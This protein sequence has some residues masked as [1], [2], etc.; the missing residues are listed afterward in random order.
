MVGR[1]YEVQG[2]G[3]ENSTSG[4]RGPWQVFEGGLVHVVVQGGGWPTNVLVERVMRWSE[5]V[6]PNVIHTFQQGRD[7][8]G[9]WRS[10]IAY[11]GAFYPTFVHEGKVWVVTSG[12]RFVRPA[13]GM[14]RVLASSDTVSA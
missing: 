1:V 5:F 13:R 8:R 12:E 14:R 10:G 7:W 6:A 2:R 3:E 11:G 4:A 9:K